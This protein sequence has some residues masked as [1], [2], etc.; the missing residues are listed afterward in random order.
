VLASTYSRL[1]QNDKAIQVLRN[2]LQLPAG[3]NNP[4]LQRALELAL[5]QRLNASQRSLDDPAYQQRLLKALLEPTADPPA[6]A[7]K[8][9]GW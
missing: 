3:A 4:Q 6:V 1:G 9:I 2:G 8:L 5:S 7:L